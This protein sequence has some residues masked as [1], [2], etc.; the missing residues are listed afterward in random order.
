MPAP[1]RHAFITGGSRG[2]GLAIAQHFAANNYRITLLARDVPRLKAALATLPS[3]HLLSH[4]PHR[5]VECADISNQYFWDGGSYFGRQMHFAD[6]TSKIDV[7]VNC[8]GI[9]Q[10]S[11]FVRTSSD[12]LDEIVKTNLTG[13]MMATRFLIRNKYIRGAGWG[14]T[15]WKKDIPEK[16]GNE[17]KNVEEFSPAIINVSSL[18]GLKGGQGAVAYAASK[19]GVLGFTRAL[20]DELAVSGIRVN[21]IVPGYISTDMTVDLE[22]SK[23]LRHRIPMGRFGTPD[24]VADA[25]LFLARNQYANNCV[26]NL[27]GGL[28]AS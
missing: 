2:I 9:A 4:E 5:Y 28:S 10:S 3:S 21:A 17:V 7:L 16:D 22:K 13:M 6:S 20:S 8:A 18:L 12:T 25:A 15:K 24:E 11:A 19:A 23:E 26:L 27:D 14:R 1:I